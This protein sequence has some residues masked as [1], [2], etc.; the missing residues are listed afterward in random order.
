MS[1]M[2]RFTQEEKTLMMLYSPGTRTGLLEKLQSMRGQLTPGEQWLRELTDRT[3][4]KLTEF[5][6]AEFDAMDLYEGIEL[7][8]L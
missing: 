5:N 3:M 4:G 8:G 2:V 6:D 1:T 7:L